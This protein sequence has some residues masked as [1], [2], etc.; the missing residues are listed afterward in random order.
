MFK[1]TAAVLLAALTV[2]GVGACGTGNSDNG[3]SSEN[4]Q[5]Q[6]QE[7]EKDM[8][9]VMNEENVKLVGRTYLAENGTLWCGLSGS[10]VEFE[11]TGKKL[12]IMIEGDN[13]STSGNRNNYC[14]LAI[15]VNGER[16]VDDM[17]N[18]A[19]KLYTPIDGADTVTAQV[20]IVKLSE[21]AMS[22]MGIMPI[23]LE[24]GAD[25]KPAAVKAHRL[26]FIGDSITCG[27]GVDDEDPTHNF[28]TSTEDVT[29]AYAYKTAELLDADYSMFSISGWGIISGY[30]GDGQKHE[31]Q[32]VPLYYEKTGFS[33][34]AFD[35]TKPESIDW[36]FGRYQPEAVVINLGTNDDSYTGGNADR[37]RD[38]IDSYK[39]F[40]KTV[41]KDSPDAHIFLALG[42]MGDRL[43]PAVETVCSEYKAETGDENISTFHFTPQDANADG[44][45]ADYHPTEKTHEKAAAALS[46]EIKTVMG[47]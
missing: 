38:Y 18:D 10:G 3:E 32:Q 20:K 34:G 47:W 8:K 9:R 28:M 45:A 41:R 15:Y 39:E 13:V 6:S 17:L 26:E 43:Y 7:G 44:L 14:R 24:E 2:I 4:T 29:K 19:V 36:D 35:K 1:K 46:E 5:S 42:I 30:S 25:I 33:Y 22:T 37:E 12:D 31:D 40:L 23:N 11:F 16:A 27:Y 21:T